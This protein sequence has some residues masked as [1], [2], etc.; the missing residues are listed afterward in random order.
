MDDDDLFTGS[1]MTAVEEYNTEEL[2]TVTVAGDDGKVMIAGRPCSNNLSITFT[3]SW[4]VTVGWFLISI[5]FFLRLLR[6]LSQSMDRLT[7]IVSWTPRGTRHL[8]W[9]IS[10]KYASH[11]E[12]TKKN[13]PYQTKAKEKET[14][15]YGSLCFSIDC[16][17]HRTPYCRWGHRGA[18]VWQRFC[19]WQETKWRRVLQW[20]G[21]FWSGQIVEHLYFL[22]CPIAK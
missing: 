12:H 11:W 17:W 14:H 20:F 8:S 13:G 5:I 16:L 10:A 2:A 7:A 22:F 1:I 18:S 19:F 15:R 21:I 3:A 9:I 6:F 4:L